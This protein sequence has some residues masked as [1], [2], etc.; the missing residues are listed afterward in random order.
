VVSFTLTP[1]GPMDETLFAHE[2]GHF[3]HFSFVG[4]YVLY[5]TIQEKSALIGVREGMANIF[6][7]LFTGESRLGMIAYGDG[8][9][10]VDR[11]FHYPDR[12]FTLRDDDERVR[13][14]SFLREAYP[15]FYKQAVAT[16]VPTQ[17]ENL[18]EGYGSSSLF[19]Q[20]LWLASQTFGREEIV[21]LLIMAIRKNALEHSYKRVALDLLNASKVI[22]N[23]LLTSFLTQQFHDRGLY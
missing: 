15:V 8:L 20:P 12:L 14:S 23:Q 19:T 3:L 7:A 6:S 18:S 5:S 16:P 22:K 2:L 21:K 1:Q 9:R 17:Y 4:E 10:D 13:N 11:F